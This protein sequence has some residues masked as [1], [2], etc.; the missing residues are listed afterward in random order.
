ML[1]LMKN[2]TNFT[3]SLDTTN[4]ST[5]N[6]LF[7]FVPFYLII[8]FT[9]FFGNGLVIVSILRSHRLRTVTNTYLLN[10]AIA[11]FLL[12][13]SVPFLITTIL[14]NGWI[15]GTVLCKM[16]F[17]FIHI[18]QYV[19]SLILA[20]LSFDRWLA[21]CHPLK[22]MSFR[23]PYNC[24]IIIIACWLMSA[25]FLSPTWL[26]ARVFSDSPNIYWRR[27]L[28]QKCIIDFPAISRIP[29]EIVF[30]YYGFFVGFIFP[31][32]LITTFYLKLLIRLHRIRQK[33]QSEIKQRSHRKVTRIVLA[34]ITAYFV[35][36][37]P[38]WFLQIY[39][40]IDPLLR[41]LKL[42]PF[43]SSTTTILKSSLL[44]E[45]TH[46]TMIVGYANNSLNPILYVFLSESFREE[47]LHVLKCFTSSSTNHN[48][49][50]N[51]CNQPSSKKIHYTKKH[52]ISLEE[53][54]AVQEANWTTNSTTAAFLS[55][56]QINKK[57]HQNLNN[58]KDDLCGKNTYLLKS[59]HKYT[60]IQTATYSYVSQ[61]D[62]T[63][64][65][66]RYQKHLL[67]NP[68]DYSNIE[69]DG[70]VYCG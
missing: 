40:T 37:I 36:W 25:L 6:I 50:I 43:F 32:T 4:S 55:C 5:N 11:D 17:N 39:I 66:H 22:A 13:F 61:N 1:S 18:N 69:G 10:L 63:S 45:L 41:S 31:V 24:G 26:Y 19:S 7:Y 20:S 52:S 33:H 57:R 62:Y 34:V 47:Y 46:F 49:D 48:N 30:T 9:G 12:L 68:T 67:I 58:K 2:T 54:A 8:F 60:S 3:K 42:P 64:D 28:V 38:Y 21:V 16:Y 29:P 27:Y 51:W 70:G 44:K 65:S 35:C 53:A 15:F 23:T 56:F 59:C 14:A